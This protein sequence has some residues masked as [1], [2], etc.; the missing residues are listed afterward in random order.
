MVVLSG[1]L[2]S[3]KYSYFVFAR[4][5]IKAFPK[6]IGMFE[7]G[8]KPALKFAKEYYTQHPDEL[9]LVAKDIGTGLHGIRKYRPK[10][11]EKWHKTR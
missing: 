9:V 11:K 3:M 10:N 4:K 5:S 8:A 2:P 1:M 6:C 7:E